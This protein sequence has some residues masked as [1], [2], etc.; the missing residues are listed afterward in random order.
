MRSAFRDDQT[1][2]FRRRSD[3]PIVCR[4]VLGVFSIVGRPIAPLFPTGLSGILRGAVGAP[5]LHH[6]PEHS[7]DG[8]FTLERIR[9]YYL[10]TGGILQV[11]NKVLLERRSGAPRPERQFS[12]LFNNAHLSGDFNRRLEYDYR[13]MGV[14]PAPTGC[15]TSRQASI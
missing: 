1:W 11:S 15:F 12:G 8:E 14:A 7:Q 3:E 13:F 9:Y 4:Y 2:Y 5:G 6:G 10:I